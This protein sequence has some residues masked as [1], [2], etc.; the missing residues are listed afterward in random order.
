[1]SDKEYMDADY[2][3]IGIANRNRAC[4]PGGEPVV[5][6]AKQQALD[7]L[8]IKA[9]YL[10]GQKETRKARVARALWILGLI[11]ISIAFGWMIK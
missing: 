7:L 4:H 6:M 10:Q 11:A 5:L 2:E 1:M 8:A 9:A 3:V